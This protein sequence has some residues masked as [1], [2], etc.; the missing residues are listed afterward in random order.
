VKRTS[1][2]T[3]PGWFRDKR[4]TVMGLGLNG[5]GSG[6]ALWLMRHGA[7]V[8]VT[9]LK[10]QHA[11]APS[12]ADLERAFI[13]DS[14]HGD[15][16]L[17]HR[18][19]YVLG[20]HREEDFRDADMVIKGPG[21]P[22]GNPFIA[23]AEAAGVPV[24]TDVSL[25]FLLCPFP[26]IGITG[27][28]GKS[29]TTSL[30]AEMCRRHD[31]RTVLG[32]NIRISVMDSLDKLLAGAQKRGYTA[33]PIVLELSSWMLEGL[34]PH[35]ISPHIAVLT[36][37]NPD[38]LNRYRNMAH[39]AATKV[40]IVRSQGKDDFALLN[41]DDAR[42]AAATK[43]TK[44]HVRWFSAQPLRAGRDG[45][46]LK[47][48]NFILRDTGKDILLVPRN[49][50]RVPGEH[51]VMNA[52]TAAVAAHAAGVPL[53]HIRGAIRAFKGIPGRIET[54]GIKKG[55]TFINDTTATSPDGAIA[56]LRALTDKAFHGK[57]VLI[58][59]G[60]D[61]K[62]VFGEWAKEVRKRV[63]RLVLFDGTATVKMEAAL[64]K[65]GGF[66]STVGARNMKEAVR[67]AAGM[68]KKGDIVLLSPGCASFGLFI[69][70]F[71]R[72]DQFVRAV[73]RMR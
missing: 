11:L 10:D 53:H 18:F 22:N 69:N 7:K 2:V 51:N 47:N 9:D 33:P 57:I 32:G 4:I 70:E 13:R 40:G 44:A 6:I 73:R 62:L 8:T 56:A 12:M 19:T 16:R 42:V 63:A 26:V 45:G 21:V 37:I 55:V 35:R 48:D 60:T 3:T 66:K 58:A 72:G 15:K 49:A 27:T 41:A 30:I 34:E 68:A 46:F 29:T 52:I 25:F 65:A 67:L 14:Q 64:K 59:G 23:V 28:R 1:V 24:E 61:K 20:K 39:Y 71:D 5:G 36:N 31:R 43:H 38:H 54:V 50:L 17:F